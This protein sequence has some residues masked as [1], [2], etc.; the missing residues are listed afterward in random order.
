[1]VFSGMVTQYVLCS[2]RGGWLS[3]LV[4]VTVSSTVLLL[5]PPSVA[6]I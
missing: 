3:A 1:M 2:H 5:F 4:T 6:T